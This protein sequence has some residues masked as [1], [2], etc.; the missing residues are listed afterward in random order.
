MRITKEYL[1]DVGLI[2]KFYPTR[3]KNVGEI[4]SSSKY[5]LI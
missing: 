3:T 4:I 1:Y 2:I 5:T